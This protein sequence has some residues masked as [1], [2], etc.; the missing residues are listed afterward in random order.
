MRRR[1]ADTHAAFKNMGGVQSNNDEDKE[2]SIVMDCMKV[3][4]YKGTGRRSA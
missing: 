1:D 2:N 4:Q 3:R